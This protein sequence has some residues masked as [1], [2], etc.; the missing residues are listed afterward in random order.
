[1]LS[2]IKKLLF[3]YPLFFAVFPI[4]A[5]YSH[6]IDKI[7]FNNFI[8]PLGLSILITTGLW[9]M[10]YG[11]IRKKHKASLLLTLL[12]VLFFSYGHFYNILLTVYLNHTPDEKTISLFSLWVIILG[13]GIFIILKFGQKLQ[14]LTTFLGITGAVLILTSSTQIIGHS[15]KYN[16][17]LPLNH[18][19][20]KINTQTASFNQDGQEKPVKTPDVYYIILDGYAG[21]EVLNNLYGYDNSDFVDFLE[22]NNFNVVKNARSNY[23]ITHLSLASS[24]NMQYVN[25]L[26]DIVGVDSADRIIATSIIKNNEVL[27]ILK[28]KGYQSIHFSSGWPAT[29]RNNFADI[30]IFCG[31]INQFITALLLTTALRPF[32]KLFLPEN[33]RERILCTFSQL[34][35]IRG[36]VHGPIFIFSHIVSPHHPYVFGANGEIVKEPT[37]KT[38]GL[39][40]W[41]NKEDYVNQLIFINK[42]VKELVGKLTADKNN[43]PVIIIQSDHGSALT[44]GIEE[45][46][47]DLIQERMR[48]FMAFYMPGKTTQYSFN[49]PVNIFRLIFNNYFGSDYG[50][51]EEKNYFSTYGRPY[52]FIDVTESVR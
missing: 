32:D 42:K 2:K 16:K 26:T 36:S 49:S 9:F 44:P 35:N 7:K 34:G 30:N 31:K 8:Y 5:F 15:L 29:D 24:L 1:M 14:I 38:T 46:N 13:I 41:Q 12:L 27:K 20:S 50:M 18:Y 23:A 4:L 22:E 45:Y 19:L 3:L 43:L 39:D 48:N 10:L 11:L 37:N 28:S 40:T 33:V 51:L 21:T 25:D 17:L 52:K 47:P 6:N